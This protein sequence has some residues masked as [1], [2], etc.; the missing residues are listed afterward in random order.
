[1][2]YWMLFGIGLLGCNGDKSLTVNISPPTVTIQQPTD[3]AELQQGDSLQLRGFI[4][5]PFYESDLTQIQEAKRTYSIVDRDNY[6]I[7]PS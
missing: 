7:A 2:R 1:M 3:G 6:H 5:D 4:Q